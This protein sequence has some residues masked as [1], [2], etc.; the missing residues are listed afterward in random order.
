M[1]LRYC[2]VGATAVAA[3]MLLLSI[4]DEVGSAKFGG[5]DAWALLRARTGGLSGEWL[6]GLTLAFSGANG[7]LFIDAPTPEIETAGLLGS[8]PI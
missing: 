3:A 8:G 4:I 1:A 2:A 7:G 5:G 6:A